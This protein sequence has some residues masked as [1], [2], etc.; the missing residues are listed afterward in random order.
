MKPMLLTSANEIPVGNDWIY[1][2]KYDG[3]RCILVWDEKSP[4]FVSRNGNDLTHLFPE[5]IH[6]YT[7][8][9]EQVAP[10]LP[11]T[12]DGELVHLVNEFKSD[13]SIVQSRGRMRNENVISKHVENYPCSYIM[14]DLLRIKGKD[15]TNLPL[16]R[17]KAELRKI[18]Q[19]TLVSA[20]EPIQVI[21]VYDNA[22]KVW[23]I[24]QVNNSEGV[25]AKRKTSD[26][27]SGQRTNQW[28][29]I[30]NWRYVTVVLTKYNQE[31][32]FFHGSVYIAESLVEITVFRHGFTDEERN[33]LVDFIQTKG[34]KFNQDIWELSPSICV[35]VACIDFDGKKLRE[36]RFHE[37]N[38]DMA[39]EDV[40]WNKM[41]RQLHPIP[42]SIQITHPDKPVWPA[43]DIEKDDYIFYLQQIAP[44]L[45]P[46][47]NDRLLTAIRF[48]HGVPGES[49]YQKN[50]PDYTPDFITTKQN[51][52]IRYIVCNDLQSL[53]WLGNQLA[54]EFHVPF[55]TIKTHY[56]TEIV[57]DLDPPSV[58]AFSLAIKAALKMKA[59]FDQFNLHSF[60]K[61]SGGKGLQLY[62]PLPIDAFTY[63]ETRI[64]TEF[65]CRFLCEQ[66]PEWFTIERLKKNRNNKLYLDYVQHAE[67]KTIIAPYSPRGN[68]Q[69]LIAT[70]LYWDEVTDEL[71]PALFPMSTVLERIK[72]NG[73][74]FKSFRQIG[75]DQ[76]FEVV[77]NQLKDLLN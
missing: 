55:Q 19:S 24:A 2:V 54:L 56:P 37:F 29:K 49:F 26:W 64:F 22:D 66:E 63:E 32:G 67:G 48:P 31:N 25:V 69:G 1:E 51:D 76:K 11:I 70:P 71:R 28:L 42:P 73:D 46:F 27:L 61:T 4:T 77:L 62:I 20:K 50:A 10:F 9:Y 16:S 39:P 44:Y 35:N 3:F 36:P 60:V 74:P 33:I 23:N 41:Q 8:I 72:V 59:I 12:A 52:D 43:I 30:K 13:F 53:L 21:D 7:S 17:R 45:L 14:F 68:E 38:F 6:F 40:S 5:I 15:L 34:T 18:F 47:L 57:F 75:E 65:V 58:D